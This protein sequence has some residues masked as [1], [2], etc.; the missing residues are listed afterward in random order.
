[1]FGRILF[2]SILYI[3]SAS[4]FA[5]PVLNAPLPA[6]DTP[7]RLNASGAELEY[8]KVIETLFNE[9]SK[10]KLNRQ[11]INAFGKLISKNGSFS[12]F[13]ST[14]E[15]LMNI[16]RISDQESFYKNCAIKNKDPQAF[17]DSVVARIDITI[18]KYCR[19]IFTERLMGLSPGINFST[20]DLAYFKDS[21]PF[22]ISGENQKE[23][24]LL[25]KHFKDN[26]TELEKLSN[27]LIENF[28]EQK[29][30][31]ATAVLTSLKINS[32]F[33]KF[34]QNNLDLDDYS[35]SFFGEEFQRL[36]RNAQDAAEK[37]DAVLSKS[38]ITSAANFYLKNKN[39]IT[40][41]KAWMG[42]ILTGKALFHRGYDNDAIEVFSLAKQIN[43]K[44]DFSDTYF[45]QLWPHIINK[46]YTALKDTA[47]KIGAEKVLD[48]LDSK[49]QYWI[50]TAYIKTGDVKKG[51]TLLNKIISSSPYS[52]YSIISLKDLASMGANNGV[53]EGEILSKLISKDEPAEL[54]VEKLGEPLKNALKRYAVWL[55]LGNE[56]FATLELRYIQTLSKEE[57]FNDEAFSKNLSPQAHKEYIITNLIKLLNNQKK[58]VSSFKIF[59]DSLDSNSLSLNYKIIKFIFPLN[60]FDLIKKNSENL[61]PLII[62][63][64]IRQESAFNPEA[65]SRVGAKG[66]MQLMPATAKQFNRRVKTKNLVNPEINVAIGTKYLRQLV[67]RYDGNLIFALASYNAGE[68]RIDRW[69]KEIFRSNDPLSTIESIPF[70]ET[71][72]YVKLIYRNNFFYSLL[73]NKPV[74]N[75]PIEESFK[76][77]FNK[78]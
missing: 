75:I 18:D 6:E 52:F 59:Q 29:T 54:P 76:V 66:L 77:T 32:Q 50:A 24:I 13:N 42:V 14:Y 63:S 22:F 1:L 61:D 27:I 72:N 11:T 57:T 48:K 46:N 17:T 3:F 21:A 49:V 67:A 62:I 58:F 65:Q 10:D 60:Y 12:I 28:I 68:N 38:L 39:F 16:E 55:K 40:A 20:R 37:G 31:P 74:L 9:L 78:N 71:R 56:R 69:R 30:K 53:T 36:S 64:L 15:R 70:E 4:A 51:S 8:G 44:E 41:K 25:L 2:T 34:L 35:N 33:N 73:T 7:F 23:L 45:Y 26:A 5:S 47:E 43:S 19:G